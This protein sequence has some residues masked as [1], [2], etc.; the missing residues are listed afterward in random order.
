MILVGNPGTGKTTLVNMLC[1]AL[2]AANI[3]SGLDAVIIDTPIGLHIDELKA[4]IKEAVNSNTILFIDEAHDSP[5]ELLKS[6]LHE[7]SENKDL[8]CAFAV[9]PDRLSEFLKKAKGSVTD[10]VS[11][12]CF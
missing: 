12:T 3:M 6:L 10:V 9:Y 7:M 8:T 2:G 11:H 1:R 5:D 4:K